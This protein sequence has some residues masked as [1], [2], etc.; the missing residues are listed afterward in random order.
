MAARMASS[1]Q[2]RTMT[3]RSTSPPILNSSASEMPSASSVR[4]PSRCF[5]TPQKHFAP[6]ASTMSMPAS[7]IRIVEY[8]MTCLKI[9]S[10][11]WY[12]G[13]VLS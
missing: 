9:S 10:M 2:V 5:S 6:V 4:T 7:S 3:V 12:M 8:W 1:S 13:V 11:T